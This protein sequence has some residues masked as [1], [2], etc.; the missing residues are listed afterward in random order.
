MLAVFSGFLN[1]FSLSDS[2]DQYMVTNKKMPKRTGMFVFHL[3]LKVLIPTLP[4]SMFGISTAQFSS[5][6]N[7]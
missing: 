1:C 4:I 2:R 5:R 7:C 3:S 6:L